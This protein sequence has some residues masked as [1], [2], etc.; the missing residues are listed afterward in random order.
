MPRAASRARDECCRSGRVWSRSQLAHL[1][2]GSGFQGVTLAEADMDHSLRPWVVFAGC[3]LV[4][5][6]L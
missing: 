5:A 1:L 3:I 4:V 2:L 6:V